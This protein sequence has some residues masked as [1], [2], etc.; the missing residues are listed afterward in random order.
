MAYTVSG[1]KH[2]R[3]TRACKDCESEGIIHARIQSVCVCGGG[4]GLLFQGMGFEMVK[5]C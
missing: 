2:N 1:N 4:G 5:R 3:Y